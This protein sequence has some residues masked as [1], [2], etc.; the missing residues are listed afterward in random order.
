MSEFITMQEIDEARDTIKSYTDLKPEIGIV[1]GS[2]LGDFANS[3]INP[4]I[5]PTTE[6]PHW[7]VSTVSGHKGHLVI[8]KIKEKTVIVLQGRT[9]FYEGHSISRI[10]FPIRVM[11]RLGVKTLILTNAAGGINSNFSA[12]DLMILTDH[13]AL[14]GMTGTN[15]LMGPNLDEFGPR[16]PDMSRTYTPELIALAQQISDENGLGCQKG[17]YVWLSGPSFET[18]AEIRFLRAIGA[19]AVGM[20]TVPEAIVASHGGLRVL[21][22]SGITNK[23]D[24]DG[25]NMASH[26]EVL[27]AGKTIVPKLI[28]LLDAVLTR[29]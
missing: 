8:G 15:P 20:S 19:D 28:T 14:A 22:V 18:A 4:V 3:V 9:H 23:V 24:P 21:G 12:G 2:G 27:A 7:P 13:I 25:T 11:Q 29:L 1:L 17:V 16:F 26:E 10:G 5:I 6:I